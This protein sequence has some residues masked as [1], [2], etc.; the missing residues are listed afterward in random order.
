MQVTQLKVLEIEQ[1]LKQLG[2]L[3]S[4][5]PGWLQEFAETK[6][7][8]DNDFTDWLQFVYLPNCRKGVMFHQH[9]IVLQAKKF[10]KHDLQ[11]GK[12]LQLLVELDGMI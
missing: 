6:Q 11:K 8:D 3:R 9:N 1:E 10:W 12:L 4:E 2:L 7:M 5:P